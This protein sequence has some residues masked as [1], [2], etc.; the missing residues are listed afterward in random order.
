MSIDLK[1]I[2][3]DIVNGGNEAEDVQR[4]C[5]NCPSA[6]A[7]APDACDECKEY[8]EKLIDALYNVEHLDAFYDRYEVTGAAAAPTTGTLNCPYCGGPSGAALTVC[9][10]C[11]MQLREGSGKIQV[12]SA[13]EIPNPILEAQDLIFARRAA[14]SKYE[15]EESGG[16]LGGLL[17]AAANLMGGGDNDAFGNKMTEDEIKETAAAYRVSV[18]SY[19]NGLDNGTHLTKSAKARADSAAAAS[20]GMNGAAYGAAGAGIGMAGAAAMFGNRPGMNQMGGRPPYGGGYPPPPPPPGHGMRPPQGV[21][22]PQSVRPPQGGMNQQWGRPPQ[23]GIQHGVRPPQSGIGHPQGMRPPQGA[24]GRPP[25]GG[26][27]RPQGTRPAAPR[28]PMQGGASPLSSL[29]KRPGQAGPGKP[30]PGN[31]NRPGNGFPKGKKGK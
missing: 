5:R 11:G 31:Q 17:E 18:S 27:N 14:V 22:P 4:P 6:C 10:Y 8:K 1:G 2:L 29:G 7:I 30:G 25:Q 16:L 23:N 20:H 24:M 12:A 3:S 9:E 28:P 21:R 13:S 15:K 26:M 19:L